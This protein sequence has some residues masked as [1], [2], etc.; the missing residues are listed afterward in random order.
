MVLDS[1]GQLGIGTTSR[2]YSLEVAGNIGS[3]GALIHNGDGDT[4]IQFSTNQIGFYTGNTGNGANIQITKNLLHVS[5][6]ATLFTQD[7]LKV[8]N[9]VMNRALHL[10][11]TGG[12]SSIQAK[13]T[14]GTTNKLLIQP[15]GSA[16]EFGGYVTV[17]N[18]D[19]NT[20]SIRFAAESE[21]GIARFGSDRVGFISNNT[22]VL[23]TT[24][25]MEI[26]KWF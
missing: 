4:Y 25:D 12:N 22:P 2:N 9:T 10:G 17:A 16:T 23:A 5:A 1:S 21:T 13:L 3:N 24:A 11:L 8:D 26:T 20:P 18:G 6:S 14:N 15:S 19:Q 7:I